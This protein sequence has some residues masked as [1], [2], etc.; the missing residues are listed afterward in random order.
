MAPPLANATATYF[1]FKEVRWSMSG[2]SYTSMNVNT[3]MTALPVYPTLSS[4][5]EV[6]LDKLLPEI[7]QTVHEYLGKNYCYPHILRQSPNFCSGFMSFMKF[8]WVKRKTP[9]NFDLEAT[10]TKRKHLTN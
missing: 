9:S 4:K 6:L 3:W 10:S 5:E 7:W 1:I 2:A 8:N